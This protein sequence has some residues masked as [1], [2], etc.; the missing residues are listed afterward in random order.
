M[1]EIGARPASIRAAI[2]PTI[3]QTAYEVGP[4][5]KARFVEMNEGLARFFVPSK[6]SGHHMFNL[7]GFVQLKLEEA[8]VGTIENLGLCTYGDEARFFSY[9]RTTHRKEPEA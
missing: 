9:R 4:E 8:G 3:S 6:R 1:A 2:G 5:F 7:P